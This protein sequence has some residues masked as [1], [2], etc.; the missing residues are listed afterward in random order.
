[1]PSIIPRRKCRPSQIRA[2][3]VSRSSRA[4]SGILSYLFG[5]DS[6]DLNLSSAVTGTDR[7]YR[8]AARLDRETMNARIWLGL[9]FRQA[10]TDGNQ[11]GHDAADWGA[12]HYFQPTD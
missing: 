4:A 5:A 1:M 10:M 2:F 3:I 8:T 11:L 7:H 6:I 12:T 9:H